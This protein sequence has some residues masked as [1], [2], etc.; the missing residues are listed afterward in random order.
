MGLYTVGAITT[1]D[2][3]AIMGTS[4]LITL[5][6]VLTNLIVDQIYAVIDPR[7]RY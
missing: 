1:M 7:I 2:Y 6:Y 4:F 3:M 5:V